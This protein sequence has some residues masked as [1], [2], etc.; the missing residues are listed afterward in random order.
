MTAFVSPEDRS[1]HSHSEKT[2]PYQGIPCQDG[3]EA[4]ID[5]VAR[6]FSESA[7]LRPQNWEPACRR[8]RLRS[9]TERSGASANNMDALLH[10]LGKRL[11]KSTLAE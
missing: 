10:S 3:R 2:K 11:V 9:G 6:I 5:P 7:A 4:S 1:P 8:C